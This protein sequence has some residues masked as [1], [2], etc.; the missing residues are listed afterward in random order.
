MFHVNFQDNRT[1]RFVG[2]SF[3]HVGHVT[4][5]INIYFHC[6]F[7]RRFQMKFGDEWPSGFGDV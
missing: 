3:G 2:E 6:P 1:I 7:P 4:W 5:T